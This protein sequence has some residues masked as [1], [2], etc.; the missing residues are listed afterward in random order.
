MRQRLKFSKV[1]Y[2]CGCTAGDVKYEIRSIVVIAGFAYDFENQHLLHCAVLS[3]S[4][5]MTQRM[6]EMCV[7]VILLFNFVEIKMT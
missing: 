6:V 4:K 5:K 7:T 3:K 2:S 1:S